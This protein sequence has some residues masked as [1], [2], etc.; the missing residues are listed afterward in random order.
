MVFLD[1]I[2]TTPLPC[3]LKLLIKY[4]S[5]ES[6]MNNNLKCHSKYHLKG[7]FNS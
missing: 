7:T 5:N 3:L 6:L 1:L 4:I 2:A